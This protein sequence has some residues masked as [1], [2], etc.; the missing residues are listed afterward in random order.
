MSVLL[1]LIK[2]FAMNGK[3]TF[4][5][6]MAVGVLGASCAAAVAA[7]PWS[8]LLSSNNVSADPDKSYALTEAN[9]PWL[10]MACS[11]SG[12]G[13]EQQA[14][15]LAYELRKR[16]KLPA[17]TYKAQFDLGQAPGRTR[18][19]EGYEWR[20]N[21]YR[22]K[23]K[24]EVDEVGVLVGNYSSADD[25]GAQETLNKLKYAQPQC[26]EIKEGK[27]TA[28]TLTG[29]RLTQ[30]WAYELIGS[31]KKKLGPMRHAFI[32][33]NPLLPPEHFAQKGIDESIIAINRGVPYSLLDCPGKYT[34]QVATFTGKVI[35]KQEEI[36][37]I[38]DGKPM[39]SE[40]A[41]AAKK[42]DA[43]TKALRMKGYEAYQFHDRYASIVTVG[44]F[45]SVGTPRP[46]GQIEINPQVHK[47][48][49]AF[50]ADP[51]AGAAL[52]DSLKSSGASAMPVKSL[53]GIPFDIQPVP[54]HVPRRAISSPPRE[55]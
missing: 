31:E 53:V 14:K 42:A 26:L 7:P 21:K 9:G 43:L 23:S 44:N 18:P 46:D 37:A 3:R 41:T 17:Y 19:K 28:Q 12:K 50:G 4:R 48:M 52:P 33:T 13:A 15:D 11:F 47:V 6:W 5:L 16:Y 8:G 25:A 35:I 36:K 22:G 10:V 55:E 20:Y 29:W 30:Q 2:E 45:D 1:H 34:V 39:E 27:A 38:E 51:K 54:V 32:T 24:A 49:Q 40:L